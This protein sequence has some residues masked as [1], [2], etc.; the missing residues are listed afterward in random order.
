MTTTF[1]YVCFRG[2]IGH[3]PDIAR[4]PTTAANAL[5]DCARD[6]V[7]LPDRDKSQSI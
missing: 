6:A 2:N 1:G 3:Q 4:L 7:D 5:S